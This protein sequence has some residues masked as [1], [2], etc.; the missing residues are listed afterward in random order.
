MQGNAADA[1]RVFDALLRTRAI[2]V[3]REGE[4]GHA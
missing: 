3:Q 1:E 4:A 2:A